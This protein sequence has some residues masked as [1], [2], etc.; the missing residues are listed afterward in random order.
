VATA[1]A[2]AD[3]RVRTAGYKTADGNALAGDTAVV[4]FLQLLGRAARQARTYPATSPLCI[5]AIDACGRAYAALDCKPLTF[6][7]ASREIILEDR[8]A[9]R[10]SIIEQ[11][12]ARP[13]H[14]ARVVSVNIDRAASARDW[15][16]FCAAL[17]SCHRPTETKTTFAELLLEAGVGAITVRMSP[18]P[19][20]FEFGAPPPSIRSL[21]ERERA[22]Q[23]PGASGKPVQYFYPPDKGWIRFDPSV[24]Y[25]SVSLLDLAVLVND[26]TE[27]AAILMRLTDD[28]GEDGVKP[29]VALEEKYSDVVTLISALDPRFARLLFTKLARAVLDLDSGRRQ[30]LLRR[31][32]LPGLLDGRKDSEAV[33]SEFPDVDLAEALCLLLDLEAAAPELLP[34]AVDRLHLPSERRTAVV[35]LI[36]ARLQS[37][38]AE[39][40]IDRRTD[41]DLSRYAGALI[42]I[43]SASGRNVADFAAFDLSINEQTVATLAS[44][45]DTIAATDPV[46]ARLSCLS[47]LT[48]LEPNPAVVSV[49]VERS[50]ESLRELAR[51]ARW[52]QLVHWLNRF[53]EIG[54]ALQTSRPEVA[55]A[56]RQV[57]VRFCDRNLVLQLGDLSGRGDR[58][59]TQTGA[60]VAALGRSIIPV[61]L[62]ALESAADRTRLGPLTPVLCARAR[63][64]APAVVRSLSSCGPEALCVTVAL[65]G[66]AG[67]GYEAAIAAQLPRCGERDGHEALR[68][69]ARIGTS[70]AAA[71]VV[72]QL[73][74]GPRWA[75]AAAEDALWR[76][77]TAM[78]VAKAHELLGRRSFVGR[79]PE[80]AGR[81]LARV[82]HVT[83]DGLRPLLERLV[84]FRY[85]FWN[86]AAA[87]VGA[88]ARELLQ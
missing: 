1:T 49:F 66:T 54:S 73:E 48:R 42:R 19:E 68:A 75:S 58:E 13:L 46:D 2:N 5:D 29:G 53:I 77:P 41:A 28:D 74:N 7:V 62:E 35:P 67:V 80:L 60:I 18:R 14:R 21:V 57:S 38:P 4:D 86:P 6:R 44:I 9:G 25:D 40:K 45:R 43:D 33:L 78:A 83:N 37:G 17:I 72:D 82:V 32:I 26:P 11:E 56:V 59:R 8:R 22:R 65:L 55:D 3:Y 36:K 61:W 70:K 15:S 81:L 10:G 87:R 85:H 39:P 50:L 52:P 24:H 64:L 12:L 23:S 20:V 16:Q 47:S 71:V 79:H 27:L 88:K 51:T 34:T 69:L 30:L 63:E 84:S 76:L 31:S